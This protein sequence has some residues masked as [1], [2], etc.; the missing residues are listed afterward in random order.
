LK[1]QGDWFNR[2]AR[3]IGATLECVTIFRVLYG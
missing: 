2:P 3:A 1:R